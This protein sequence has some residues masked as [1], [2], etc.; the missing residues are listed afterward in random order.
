MVEK[1]VNPNDRID[2]REALRGFAVALAVP[3]TIAAMAQGAVAD[4]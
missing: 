3:A 4:D 1:N 2:R